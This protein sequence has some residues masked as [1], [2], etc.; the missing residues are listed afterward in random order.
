MA[1]ASK[2]PEFIVKLKN[3]LTDTLRDAGIDATVES[4]RVP[5]TKLHRVWVFAPNF[6]KMT[7]SERQ[8]FV[9]R[10]AEKAIPD[11][12]MRISMIV[13]LTDEEAGVKPSSQAK[14]ARASS[15]R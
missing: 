3:E 11:D 2:Q 8:S 9:W 6:K 1:A 13:T 12:Q 15:A 7:H 4:E 10:I 5:M 14:R